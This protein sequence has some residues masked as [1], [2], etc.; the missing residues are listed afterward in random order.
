MPH[1]RDELHVQRRQG[2]E[3]D[4]FLRQE[5]VSQGLSVSATARYRDTSLIVLLRGF[6]RSREAPTPHSSAES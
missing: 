2:L 5:E 3:E 1:V 6:I 4:G